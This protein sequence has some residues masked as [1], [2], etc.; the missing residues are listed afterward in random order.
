M[1]WIRTSLLNATYTDEGPRDAHPIL[2]L[3]GWPDDACTWDAVA[4]LLNDAGYR[5]IAPTLRGF[6]ET[7]FLSPQTARTGNAA[8]L[9][10]AAVE[11]LDA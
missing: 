10:I 4:P 11:M 7:H 6:G 9:A 8:V 2:L 3:H 1:S 5:T